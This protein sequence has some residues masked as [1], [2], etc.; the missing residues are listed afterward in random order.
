MVGGVCTLHNRVWGLGFSAA[1]EVG[2]TLS[3]SCAA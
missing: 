2:R 3:V 1:E